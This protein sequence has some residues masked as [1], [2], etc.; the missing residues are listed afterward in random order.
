MILAEFIKKYEGKYLDW[1]GNY[2][3]QC[4]DLYRYYVKE[5]LGYPQ[6]APVSGAAD[7]WTSYPEAYYD[8]IANTPTN[9]P[10]PGDIVI[11]T[12]RYGPYGHV[13]IVSSATADRFVCFSQNDPT[14]SPSILKEYRYANIYGWLH[15]KEIMPQ[16]SLDS[17]TFESLVTKSSHYDEFCKLGYTSAA[18]VEKEVNDLKSAISDKNLTIE[19]EE[20]RADEARKA[21]NELVTDCAKAL[22]TVQEVTQI[23]ASL[24]KTSADLD[25]LEDLQR[26]FAELQL[27]SKEQTESLNAEIAKWKAIAE[28]TANLGDYETATLIKEIIR[29]FVK[30]IN[31]VK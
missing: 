12:R 30:V 6:S 5:V 22:N 17:A 13:A 24:M 28:Q 16:V 10:V 1:D 18:Q 9:Q 21:F 4:T 14:G 29:R 8:K 19:V 25:T 20:Q 2:G 3:N 15:P 27:H 31:L 7:I 26:N 11:W 23:K